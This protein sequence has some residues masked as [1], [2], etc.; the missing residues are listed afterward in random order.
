[1]GKLNDW[2]E[3]DTNSMTWKELAPFPGRGRRH[4]AMNYVVGDEP[5]SVTEIHVGLGDGEGGNYNDWW[6]YSILDNEWTQ[7]SDFPSTARHHPFHFS[8]GTDSYVGLGHS[9]VVPYIERD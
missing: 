4:P 3:F 8:I 2:W 7:L 6:S 9:S 1:M 5:S